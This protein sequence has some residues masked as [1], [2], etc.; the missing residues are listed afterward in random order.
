MSHLELGQPLRVCLGLRVLGHSPALLRV[1]TSGQSEAPPSGAETPWI[2]PSWPEK[3]ILHDFF[4]LLHTLLVTIY[5][6]IVLLDVVAGEDACLACFDIR[7]LEPSVVTPLHNGVQLSF[8]QGQLI[9]L[10]SLV[11]EHRSV[12]G[13]GL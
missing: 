11:L 1:Q 9:L 13:A 2:S 10:S 6:A 7:S 12:H 8:S 4:T 3:R 5:L